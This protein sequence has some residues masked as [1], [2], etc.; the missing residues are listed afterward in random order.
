MHLGSNRRF[1]PLLGLA[2]MTTRWCKRVPERNR[3]L[4]VFVSSVLFPCPLVQVCIAESMRTNA[5]IKE[6]NLGSNA[7]TSAGAQDLATALA[8]N[9]TLE[10]LKLKNNTIGDAGITSIFASV[11]DN[12]GSALSCVDCRCAARENALVLFEFANA[13]GLLC[14]APPG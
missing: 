1:A 8:E 4:T 2:L 11:L 14:A 7:F 5:F 10:T 9:R 6:L 13:S 3:R 12:S